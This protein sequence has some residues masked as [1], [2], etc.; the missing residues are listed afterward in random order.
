[1]EK[2]LIIKTGYCEMLDKSNNSR[3]VSLGD[4][5]RVT[6]LLNAFKD[7]HV[8]WV[9]DKYSFPLLKNNLIIDRL[10]PYDF[11]TMLQLESEEFDTLVNLEKVPGICALSDKMHIRKNRYGFGF[12]SK[13]GEAVALD[14]A[15]EVLDV[16][17]RPKY[18][19]E[20]K[21][22]SQS[23]LFNMIG[24]EWNGEDYVLG[25]IPITKKLYDVGLNVL[26]GTKWPNKAWPIHKWDNLERKLNDAGLSVTRQD[27][28]GQDILTNL[29]SYIGWMNSC[30]M[31]ITND[32]L[33]THLSLALKKKTLGL[34]G[35]TPHKE[36]EFYGRGKAIYAT[37]G[38]DCMP[39]FEPLCSNDKFCMDA[40]SVNKVYTEAKKLWEENKNEI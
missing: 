13:R 31:I 28:R 15:Y 36:F 35:P 27:K 19:K 21:K 12:D 7:D 3:T 20:N 34:F 22:T 32:S 25:Y 23:L 11:T 17:S 14:K 9:A 39:C 10:L 38:F 1:M 37:R 5:L 4:V 8:T 29:N 2:V 18:K 24:K 6:P 40:I 16:S 26:V 30:E 33:G